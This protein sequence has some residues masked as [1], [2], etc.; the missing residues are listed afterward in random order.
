M[1]FDINEIADLIILYAPKVLGAIITLVIGFW[2]A[3]LLSSKI[4]KSLEKNN[5]DKSL[6][7]FIFSVVSITLK[8]LVLLSAASMFG[9]EVTSFIAIF[10]ALAFAIGLALQ[11]NL[12]HMAAGILILFFKP[13][14]VGDFI[15]TNGYSGTVKEIQIFN[16]IL[17][18]LD[19]RI[20]IVPNGAIASNPLENLTANAE[21]K[22]PMTFGISYGADIDKARSVIKEVA[23]SCEF[24][25]HSKPIDILV[26]ELADSSVN[27]AVRPWCKTEDFWNVHFFMQENIK[28]AFDKADI[29]IPFPQRDVHHFYPEGKAS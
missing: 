16:T 24:I 10:S 19:N 25:D 23:A 9:I 18:T 26:S 12:S 3:G 11:G 5:V 2:I 27:F 28:K 6:A 14:R 7:P 21:R 22:V 17:T 20:I 13:F 1:E 29:G 15:V 8:M 4:K